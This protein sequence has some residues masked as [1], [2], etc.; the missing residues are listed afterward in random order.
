MQ[1]TPGPHGLHIGGPRLQNSLIIGG[2]MSQGM[3][4][5]SPYPY[6]NSNMNQTGPP[7][8]FFIFSISKLK[9]YCFFFCCSRCGNTTAENSWD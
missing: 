9:C 8:E 2:P 6:S 4:G 5:N 3:P 7:G 1:R